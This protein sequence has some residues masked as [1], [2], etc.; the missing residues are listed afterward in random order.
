MN[1]LYVII[2][3]ILITHCADRKLHADNA[4]RQSE[5]YELFAMMTGEFSSEEQA[6]E[7]SL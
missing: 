5:I 4:D 6:K 7:D 2:G 3:P 1:K